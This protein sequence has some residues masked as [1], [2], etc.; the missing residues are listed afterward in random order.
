MTLALGIICD[1]VMMLIFKAPLIRLRWRRK[2]IAKHPGFWGIMDSID[3]EDM[4]GWPPPRACLR[5]RPRPAAQM[6]AAET[7]V[8]AEGEGEPGSVAV[9]AV[10]RSRAAS[11]SDINFPRLLQVFSPWPPSPWWRAAAPSAS[12]A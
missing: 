3:V 7:R 12:A 1:I 9:T 8:I 2:V 11:S 10:R 6:N 4:P 5:P